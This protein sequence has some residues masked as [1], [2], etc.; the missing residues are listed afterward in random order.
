[1]GHLEVR[2]AFTSNNEVPSSDDLGNSVRQCWSKAHYSC[3][4]PC[5]LVIMH[6]ASSGSYLSI[7]V[8]YGVEMLSSGRFCKYHCHWGRCDLRHLCA[9]GARRI[10]WILYAWTHDR[11]G[12]RSGGWRCA[13]AEIWVE[14]CRLFAISASFCF[15]RAVQINFLVLMHRCINMPCYNL[16]VSPHSTFVTLMMRLIE[17]LVSCQK[18]FLRLGTDKTSSLGYYIYPSFQ[19]WGETSSRIKL[20]TPF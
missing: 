7:L 2:E 18:H 10:L 4:S 14:V 9:H 12:Y 11:S 17:G 15:T 13:G 5:A 20:E 8:A 6:R 19:L 16:N 3:L 1:M